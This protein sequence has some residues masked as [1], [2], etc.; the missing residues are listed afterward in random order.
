MRRTALFAGVLGMLIAGAQP[1][2]A[3]TF[4]TFVSQA[5]LMAQYSGSSSTIGFSYAG[6]K[7]V[8]SIYFNNQLYQTDL[9]GQSVAKF[10]APLPIASGVA[11]EIYVSSSLGLGGFASRAIF[12][13][14]EA[15][16][17]VWTYANNATPATAAIQFAT[18][19][20]GDV[21]SIAFDPYGNYG[22]NM[23]VATQTGNVYRINSAGVPTL[24]ASLGSDSEGL[25]F[26]P[27]QFGNIP[28]GTLV[29]LSEGSGRVTAIA[30]NGQKTDLGLQFIAPEMLSFVPLDFALTL[31]PLAGFYAADYPVQVIKAASSDFAAYA[32]QA[33]VTEETTH[34]VFAISWDST[35]SSF[36]AT[37]IGTFPHQPEDGI[38]VTAAILD[39]G[40][41]TRPGGCAQV[42]EP[43]G[44]ALLLAG[45]LGMAYVGQ[46]RRRRAHAY[47]QRRVRRR[48]L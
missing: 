2:W 44:L 42:P 20:S 33:I 40:C 12:A 14:S 6:D 31:D 9:N 30:P 4:N 16:G 10:G 8:G 39:P 29:V 5:D 11:G 45:L 28:A 37:N 48:C 32:G 3:I 21:R 19:L 35:S 22:Y 26:T 24:L 18:G 7:F 13:G 47:S 25:D 15:A 17:T 38:F 43:G 41:T 36:V 34:R 27:Q 1:A 46:Q 23:V